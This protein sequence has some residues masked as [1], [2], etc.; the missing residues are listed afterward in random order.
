MGKASPSEV[1]TIVGLGFGLLALELGVLGAIDVIEGNEP[2]F[3][4]TPGM[5]ATYMTLGTMATAVFST[6]YFKESRK[7]A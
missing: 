4:G 2:L 6:L 1:F 7:N 5:A 3:I